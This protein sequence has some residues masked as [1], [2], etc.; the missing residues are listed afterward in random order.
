[1]KKLAVRFIPVPTWLV[2]ETPTWIDPEAAPP[3]LPWTDLAGAPAWS[4][5]VR[6]NEAPL[7]TAAK[8]RDE[9]LFPLLRRQAGFPLPEDAPFSKDV[10][11]LAERLFAAVWEEKEQI[12]DALIRNLGPEA[13]RLDAAGV[14]NPIVAFVRTASLR[15]FENEPWP[16]DGAAAPAF[17]EL[18]RAGS[19]LTR[20]SNRDV[21]ENLVRAAA[22]WCGTLA[23]HPEDSRAALRVLA[24]LFRRGDCPA[25]PGLAEALV[26]AGAD[27]W[28]GH[29]VRAHAANNRAWTSRG[30]GYAASVTAKGWRGFHE[31]LSD[32]WRAALEAFRLHPEFPE[33]AQLL[34]KI[35]GAADGCGDSAAADLWFARALEAEI[36]AP[37][38]YLSYLWYRC[39]PRW[40][41]SIRAMERFARACHATHRHDTMIP[42]M[43]PNAMGSVAKEIRIPREE[44]LAK[45]KAFERT[46]EV[47][48][49][50]A[51]NGNAMVSLRWKAQARLP[52]FLWRNGREE[53]AVAANRIKEPDANL[54]LDT[55]DRKED[56]SLLDLLCGPHGE[57]LLPLETRWHAEG[58]PRRSAA[59]FVPTVRELLARSDWT[60]RERAHLIRRE[61]ELR[62]LVP[63]AFDP[64][65]WIELPFDES[66][67]L[68]DFDEP[69]FRHA[70]LALRGPWVDG[71]GLL[72]PTL[73][74]PADYELEGVAVPTDRRTWSVLIDI[75]PVKEPPPPQ[76][77]GTSIVLWQPATRPAVGWGFW[78]F[79]GTNL[80]FV[81]HG[82]ELYREAHE[83]VVDWFPRSDAEIPFRLLVRGNR[84]SLRLG[85]RDFLRD[86]ECEKTPL[87]ADRTSCRIGISLHHA[88]IRSLRFR[89]APPEN[90]ASSPS[91]P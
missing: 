22:T 47:Y 7:R 67:S 87:D 40:G 36:D 38:T 28:L 50:L 8:F 27:P 69:S 59:A 62:L 24:F 80:C 41:G 19:V 43:Y 51:T 71:S 54:Q 33:A 65:E 4:A 73:A 79:L 58:E 76:S 10:E 57:A 78:P 64:S 18:L 12:S 2:G 6:T 30:G 3:A 72:E 84:V 83:S 48:S 74:L 46:V 82:G 52:V 34:L 44:F 14:S 23:S 13:D 37:R 15:R 9:S 75:G 35:H 20:R 17:S 53:D 61:N 39:Y 31:G 5:F 70:N 66:F 26:E 21:E 29:I 85:D 86:R 63:A 89:P 49:A 81:S 88:A 55:A 32:A 45:G 56:G 91:R 16:T 1:M 25:P 90:G 42:E 60:A 11:A 77:D 68:F